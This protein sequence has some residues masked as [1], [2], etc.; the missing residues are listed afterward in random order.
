MHQNLS[1]R[2]R[3]DKITQLQNHLTQQRSLF[4]SLNLQSDTVVW[5]RCVVC[6]I[7]AKKDETF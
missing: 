2:V 3:R 5:A 4:E 7:L 1:G 6:E